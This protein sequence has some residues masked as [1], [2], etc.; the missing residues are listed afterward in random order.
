MLAAEAPGHAE[1]TR[2]PGQRVALHEYLD[3]SEHA[4]LGIIGSAELL[5]PLIIIS[6]GGLEKEQVHAGRLAVSKLIK[7]IMREYFERLW[8]LRFQLFF[9]CGGVGG[10]IQDAGGANS[11]RFQLH[12]QSSGLPG[13]LRLQRRSAV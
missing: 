1:P 4:M 3:A 13:D 7:L 6:G 11:S 9:P 2:Q 12:P 8:D 10:T 5:E